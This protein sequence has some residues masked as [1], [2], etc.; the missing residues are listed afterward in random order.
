MNSKNADICFNKSI[1]KSLK[2]SDSAPNI[3][4]PGYYI[5]NKEKKFLIF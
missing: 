3:V 2:K 1:T 4:G 5:T